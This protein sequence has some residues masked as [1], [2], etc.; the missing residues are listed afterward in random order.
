MVFG[1]A[2]NYARDLILYTYTTQDSG[3][4][5]TGCGSD[6]EYDDDKKKK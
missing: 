4:G 2:N 5:D 1:S 3:C 6:D